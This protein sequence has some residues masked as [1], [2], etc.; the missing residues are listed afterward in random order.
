M[1]KSQE[2]G[3]DKC[4]LPP[5]T[6]TW[7]SVSSELEAPD[8]MSRWEK[9]ALLFEVRRQRPHHPQTKRTT[10]GL[11]S[12]P[13]STP[14]STIR[15]VWPI[16]KR[17][18]WVW[19]ALKSVRKTKCWVLRKNTFG[20]MNNMMLCPACM[21]MSITVGILFGSNKMSP[22]R[23]VCLFKW[24]VFPCRH[25]WQQVVSDSCELLRLPS[26]QRKH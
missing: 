11:S 21:Q 8:R 2:G 7:R 6:L 22:M 3:G 1:G 26:T 25:L 4:V 17:K 23:E 16:P 14:H 5:K 18:S 9:C 19:L 15:G 12:F 10:K 13:T 20:R 24:P